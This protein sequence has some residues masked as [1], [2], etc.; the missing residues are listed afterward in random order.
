MGKRSGRL[1]GTNQKLAKMAQEAGAEVTPSSNGNVILDFG[2]GQ[3]FKI[4]EDGKADSGRA[5]RILN[6]CKR[7]KNSGKSTGLP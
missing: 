2:D 3:K 7:V 6:R 4:P 1:P 5:K